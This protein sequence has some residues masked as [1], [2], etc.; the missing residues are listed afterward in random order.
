MIT[1]R[2]YIYAVQAL[3]TSGKSRRKE[4]ESQIFA[5]LRRRQ[6]EQLDRGAVAIR[7][8]RGMYL[9]FRLAAWE[10]ESA[11]FHIYADG[12][13]IA[14]IGKHDATNYLDKKGDL[15]TRYEIKKVTNG[16]EE[17]KQFQSYKIFKCPDCGQK[18]RIP[19]HKG[20]IEI[21]CPK[22]KTKFIRKS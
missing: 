22:C 18:I 21:T 3:S 10:Y 5:P 12:K 14:Q 6:M 4:A 11:E 13:R 15:H 16:K 1:D 8:R 19:R 9:T 7:T 2:S 17:G 20:R